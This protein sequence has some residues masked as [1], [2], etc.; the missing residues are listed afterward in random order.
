MLKPLGKRLLVQPLEVKHGSLFL[1]GA[2]PTQF[3]VIAVGDEVTKVAV[4]D[5]VY[6]EKHY[7][8]EIQH[9]GNKF[10]V[11]DEMTILAKAVD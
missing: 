11:I 10:L 5:M 1:A 9:E 3:R 4:G 8:V 2:K 6:L 7:G